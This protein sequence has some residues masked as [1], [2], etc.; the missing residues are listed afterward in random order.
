MDQINERAYV[1]NGDKAQKRKV[2]IID[3]NCLTYTKA[4]R[5]PYP[6]SYENNFRNAFTKM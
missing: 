4:Q 2:K 3:K 5:I 6:D 1:G